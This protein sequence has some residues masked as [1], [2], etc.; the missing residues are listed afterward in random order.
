MSKSKRIISW[1]FLLGWMVLIFYMSN[2]PAD[3]SNSQSE[4]VIMIFNYIGI[5]LNDYFGEL[6]SLVVRKGAHFTEYLI[7]FFFSYN[8]SKIYFE[9]RNKLY[10]IM[11]VFLYAISDEFHQYFIPGREM[12]FLDVIIDTCG[13]IFGSILINIKNSLKKLK[14]K[15]NI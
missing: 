2:Q 7:L 3:I 14:L 5:E 9:K 1:I 10:S 4:F 15:K 12:K 11:F 8:L 6:A 13:G